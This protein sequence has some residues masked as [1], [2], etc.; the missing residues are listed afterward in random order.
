MRQEKTL[1]GRYFLDVPCNIPQEGN[2]LYEATFRCSQCSTYKHNSGIAF[3]SK[4]IR[5]VTF[6]LHSDLNCISF[7]HLDKGNLSK[8]PA[9]MLHSYYF[10]NILMCSLKINAF[11]HCLINFNSRFFFAFALCCKFASC[12]EGDSLEPF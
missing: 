5:S 1:F 10:H 3:F 2:P 4:G 11:L 6:P 7:R 9:I 12:C 8:T